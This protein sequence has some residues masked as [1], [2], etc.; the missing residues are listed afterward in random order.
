MNN[1]CFVNYTKDSLLLEPLLN[2]QYKGQSPRFLPYYLVMKHPIS[3]CDDF[4]SYY[5]EWKQGQ[6]IA[7]PSICWKGYLQPWSKAPFVAMN[8]FQLNGNGRSRQ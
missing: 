4:G 3:S 8:V 6:E 2:G 1:S 7:C 5:L